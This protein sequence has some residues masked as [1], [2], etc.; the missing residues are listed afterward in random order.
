MVVTAKPQRNAVGHR[1]IPLNQYLVRVEIAV[2]RPVN[3]IAVPDLLSRLHSR[4]AINLSLDTVPAR[5]SPTQPDTARH[6]PQD[7][8]PDGSIRAQPMPPKPPPAA[9]KML[10]MVRRFARR[11]V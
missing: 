9:E 5:H 4:P 2:P 1:G 8:T 11:S 6:S 10:E 7:H 3:E